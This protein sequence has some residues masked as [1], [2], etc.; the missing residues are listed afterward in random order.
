MSQATLELDQ[1]QPSENL[2]V[3][4]VF[5]R[6]RLTLRPAEFLTEQGKELGSS[7][8]HEE[9]LAIFREARQADRFDPHGRYLEAFTLL[10]LGQYADAVA[11]YQQ[12]EELAPGWFHCREDAWLAEQLLLGR[13]DHQDLLLLGTLE[14]GPDSP[15]K[16]VAV[17]QELI[18][19]RP[20]LPAAYLHL[21]K[22]QARSV[23]SRTFFP[24]E[25]RTPDTILFPTSG[26][27]SWS[28]SAYSEAPRK[29]RRCFRK[30]LS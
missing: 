11:V 15:K 29:A 19:R 13:L 25:N 17:A 1:L 7:G 30:R 9:A 5:E 8:R 26:P 22:N 16:K 6:N 2:H 27:G 4:F 28:K 21:G 20:D 24:T 18:T 23:A 14:D 10:Q 3:Q 12:V